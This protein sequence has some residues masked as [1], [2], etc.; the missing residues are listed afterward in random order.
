MKNAQFDNMQKLAFGK[1]NESADIKSR[2]K[3]LVA[4]SL[5]EAKKT[6]VPKEFKEIYDEGVEY[7]EAAGD[8]D[9]NPY[10]KGTSEY[11][12]W[13][14]GYDDNTKSLGIW[15]AKKKEFEFS[16]NY[17]TDEDDVEYINN[18]LMDANADAVAEPGIDSEEM[19]VKAP[20]AVELRR[21]KKAIEQE[22]FEINENISEAKKKKEKPEDIIPQ[23]DE[24]EVEA[25]DTIEPDHSVETDI[26]PKVK[27][28]QNALQTAFAN[29]KALG[30]EKLMTQIGN[31]ITYFTRTQVLGNHPLA[32]GKNE[33]T[34]QSIKDFHGSEEVQLQYLEI[35]HDIESRHTD[36]A[37]DFRNL[38]AAARKWASELEDK[39]EELSNK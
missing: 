20:N 32:E 39:A 36:D 35:L 22:G 28:V 7:C 37:A 29:A 1:V 10:D 27:A 3:E 30:D 38:A 8:K 33:A 16:F 11:K 12:W 13:N 26:D 6:I 31:S 15:E 23:E 21:A 18:I 4:K 2:I 17:N 19:I 9:E 24:I 5:G 14:K 34:W 25:V